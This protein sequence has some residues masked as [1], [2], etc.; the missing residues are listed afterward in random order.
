MASKQKVTKCA[1]YARVSTSDKGQTV[2]NQIDPLK[3]IAINNNWEIYNYYQESVSAVKHRPEL[4]NLKRDAKKHKF[5]IILVTKLDRLARST[6]DLIGLVD[7]IVVQNKVRLWFVDQNL[8]VD[9]NNP[10]NMLT[11]HILAAMAEFERSLISERVK[12]GISRAIA[13]GKAFG[14]P[15]LFI[16]SDKLRKR[17]MEGASLTDLQKEFKASRNT[18]ISRLRELDLVTNPMRDFNKVAS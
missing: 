5:D 10:V 11:M 7:E 15:K 9:P 2:E 18:I 14:K 6:R 12:A 8:D 3:E 13:S 1:I 16:D 4:T 17:K